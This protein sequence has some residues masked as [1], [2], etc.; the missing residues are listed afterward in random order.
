MDIF[1]L[2]LADIDQVNKRYF[3]IALSTHVPLGSPVHTA[4]IGA[5]SPVRIIG[6]KTLKLVLLYLMKFYSFHISIF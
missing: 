2:L 6:A 4:S 3:I 5:I 1:L